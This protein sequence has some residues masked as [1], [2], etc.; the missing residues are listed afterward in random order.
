M[1]ID[2]WTADTPSDW[3]AGLPTASS[4]VAIP[5]I[6]EGPVEVT[7]SFGTVNSINNAVD[8]SFTDAGANVVG[9]DASA[10]R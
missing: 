10:E 1:A 8:L 4:D 3:S 9:G 5:V 7:A 6:D 2:T